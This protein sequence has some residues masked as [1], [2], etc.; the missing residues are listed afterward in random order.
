M[1]K[2]IDEK[3]TSRYRLLILEKGFQIKVQGQA[4]LINGNRFNAFS[5]HGIKDAV[6]ILCPDEVGSMV[7]CEL[8]AAE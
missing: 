6:A 4:V 2:I 3:Q 7:G 5:V 8:I 1:S